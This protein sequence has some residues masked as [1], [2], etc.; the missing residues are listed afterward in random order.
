MI[1]LQIT[2]FRL[3]TYVDHLRLA[4]SASLVQNSGVCQREYSLKHNITT[5]QKVSKR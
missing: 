2:M 3:Q 4:F 5:L 1:L